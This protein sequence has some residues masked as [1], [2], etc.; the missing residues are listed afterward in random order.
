[1][2]KNPTE[3]WN[4]ETRLARIDALSIMSCRILIEFLTKFAPLIPLSNR[5]L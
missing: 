4:L 5:S 1:M 3:D 2:V